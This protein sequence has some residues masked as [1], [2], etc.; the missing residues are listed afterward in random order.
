MDFRLVYEGPLQANGSPQH[1]Q[2]IRRYLRP[3]VGALWT[4]PPLSAAPEIQMLVNRGTGPGPGNRPVYQNRGPFRFFPLVASW[5]DLTCGLEILFLRREA[6]GQL[7]T[8]GGDI[9]NRLKT[10]FDALSV[11]PPEQVPRGDTPAADE[12]PFHCLLED[13]HL[14]TSVAITT[15]RLLR[16]QRGGEW[17]TDVVLVLKV[18]AVPVRISGANLLIAGT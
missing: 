8:P 12:D 2:E 18:R 7:I 1:K 14:V 5:L 16:P 4:Q 17:D 15:D 6:P 13:D 9:D 3:Q 10:L 11:P